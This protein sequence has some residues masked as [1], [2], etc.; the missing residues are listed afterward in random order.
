L[1]MSPLEFA[2]WMETLVPRSRLLDLGCLRSVRGERLL[3]GNL[4]RAPIA[5]S[6]STCTGGDMGTLSFSPTLQ[7]VSASW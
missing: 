5:G 7:W 4:F 3:Y 1:A 6:G 2:Q